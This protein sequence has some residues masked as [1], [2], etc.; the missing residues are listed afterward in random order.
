MSRPLAVEGERSSREATA[1]EWGAL[2]IFTHEASDN[3][4]LISGGNR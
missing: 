3:D 4:D 1:E 2:T